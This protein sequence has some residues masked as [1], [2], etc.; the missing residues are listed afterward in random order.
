M[1][2]Y[3]DSS[4]NPRNPFGGEF[5]KTAVRLSSDPTVLVG[6]YRKDTPPTS[7]KYMC[8]RLFS[9]AI[10]IILKEI[11]QHRSLVER[12]IHIVDYC[13]AVKENKELYV[14]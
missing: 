3:A 9:A 11:A 12:S 14:K 2:T 5:G 13:T 7:S 4:A 6:I 1:L 8:T 10:F